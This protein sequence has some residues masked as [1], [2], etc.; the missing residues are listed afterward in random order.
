M[1]ST[2][3]RARLAGAPWWCWSLLGALASVGLALAASAVGA[4]PRPSSY[5]WW[6]HAGLGGYTSAHVVLYASVAVMGAA[7]LALGV[8]ARRDELSLARASATFVAWATPLFLAPPLFSRDIYSYIAQGRL[9]RA[10]LNPYHVAPNALPHDALFFSLAHVWTATP[11]PYGPLFVTL[12]R[13]TSAIAGQSLMGQVF[14]FRALELVGVALATWALADLA[15]R[16]GARVGVALWLGVLS[17]LAVFSDVASA[18]N[19]TLMIGLLLVGLALASRSLRRS[20]LVVIALAAAVKLPAL[21]AVVVLSVRDVR[22]LTLRRGALVVI[23]ALAISAAILAAC[24]LVNGFGWAWA[25]SQALSIP[26]E[27]RTLATPSVSLGAALAATVRVLGAHTLATH[28]VVTVVQRVADV[29]T[30][31]VI[32]FALTRVRATNAYRVLGFILLGVVLGGPTLW[33]WYLLW[34]LSV[35]AA[36]S[37]QSS[38]ALALVGLLATLVVGPGGSPMLGGDAY[39]VSAPAVLLGAYWLVRETRRVNPL[40]RADRV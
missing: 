2:T 24:T 1:P 16:L 27:L 25:S 4:I 33:P 21:A 12:T 9:A 22:G 14:A 6:F 32:I 18:H 28:G 37:A 39:L 8:I 13:L 26:S 5:Q 30:A 36:T 10:G 38:R 35:L 40:E 3:L 17:P 34:G 29:A 7:W 23:E 20:A 31:G 15:R 19:D 11:S